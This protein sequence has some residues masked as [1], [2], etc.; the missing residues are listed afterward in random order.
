[1]HTG[2]TAIDLAETGIWGLGA[3]PA[4]AEHELEEARRRLQDLLDA[5]VDPRAVLEPVRDSR[6]ALVDLIVTKVNPAA[7]DYMGLPSSDL[8]GE[9][10]GS[11]LPPRFLRLA[12]VAMDRVLRTGEP[13]VLDHLAIA[14]TIAG[15]RRSYDLRAIRA[16]TAVVFTWRDVTDTVR[17]Q[18]SLAE[19][20]SRYRL[21][22]E[23]VSD[24]VLQTVSGTM[25][26]L[27]PSLLTALRWRPEEW[28]GRSMED[29]THPEDV[30]R[31]Q[32]RRA[33]VS[34]GRTSLFRIRLSD[35]TGAHHWVD[36]HAGPNIDSL[37]ANIGMIASFRVI[38]AQVE[39]ERQREHLARFDSLT[40]LMNRAEAVEAVRHVVD[41]VP[42]TGSRVALLY[43]DVDHFKRVN[44]EY[45][46]A[47][48]D[49][50]LRTLGER[51]RECIRADDFAARIG[52]DEFL[53]VL[54]GLHDEREA[55]AIA[56]KIRAAA[57]EPITLYPAGV[58][59][60]GLSAGIAL[61]ASGETVE[62]FMERADIAM[63]RAK[64][65]GRNLVSA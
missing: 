64:R 6:G 19:S 29:F 58:I 31:L 7:L 37:G 20:E 3:A 41:Q 28:I 18:R 50:V 33:D 63:Y 1:M 5:D 52:G 25:T 39:A 9:R 43:C 56:E 55:R 15:S 2:G 23:H 53:I 30:A 35:S 60:P 45:G 14:R 54:N 16:G 21:L 38:D 42:R 49:L 27:S 26:W 36:M 47:T 61:D 12:L 13:I 40:G 32:M 17:A 8:V 22:A 24:V 48:G 51:I 59:R 44:D 11:L 62:E 10:V 46:H 4:A 65:A 34:Q 57:E